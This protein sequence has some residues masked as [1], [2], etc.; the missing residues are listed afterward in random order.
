M[1]EAYLDVPV[2]LAQRVQPQLVR[3]LGSIHGV[4]QILGK[5]K[6]NKVK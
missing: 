3:D 1:A 5:K 6:K 2:A 4:G